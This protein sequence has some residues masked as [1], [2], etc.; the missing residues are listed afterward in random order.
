M[1]V[2]ILIGTAQ[3]PFE[4]KAAVQLMLVLLLAYIVAVVAMVFAQIHRDTTLSH[5]TRTEPGELGG[6]FWVA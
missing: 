5:V 1:Y 6:D 2:L 3:Y 4:P